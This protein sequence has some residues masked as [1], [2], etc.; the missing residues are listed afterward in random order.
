[1]LGF[2]LGLWRRPGNRA[3][4]TVSLGLGCLWMEFAS[5]PS[6]SSVGTM[7]APVFHVCTAD[8]AFRMMIENQLR[9]GSVHGWPSGFFLGSVWIWLQGKEGLR[10]FSVAFQFSLAVLDCSNYQISLAVLLV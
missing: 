2:R 6:V 3:A 7:P 8:L 10:K 9:I 4:A 1:M 5:D